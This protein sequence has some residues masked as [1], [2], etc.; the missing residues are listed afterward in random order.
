MGT[1]ST[2]Q[3]YIAV[4]LGVIL[5]AMQLFAFIDCLCHRADAFAAAR[6][7]TKFAWLSITA[8]ATVIGFLSI[9]NPLNIFEIVAVVGTAIYLADVRPALHRVIGREHSNNS[10]P[11]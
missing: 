5:F 3:S 4:T 10:D 11:W 6:K 9:F 1:V 8:V 7:L 2:I